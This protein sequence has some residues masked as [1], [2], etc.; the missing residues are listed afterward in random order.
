MRAAISLDISISL[1]LSA[2]TPL[3]LLLFSQREVLYP[4]ALPLE[5]LDHQAIE[6][7]VLAVAMT[8]KEPDL[9]VPIC[10]IPIRQLRLR[11]RHSTPSHGPELLR[12][13]PTKTCGKYDKR[14]AEHER[15]G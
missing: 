5:V 13:D 8:E 14:N 1:S 2:S 7:G 12:C 11:T 9:P 10:W 3:E 4:V 15:V 6:V